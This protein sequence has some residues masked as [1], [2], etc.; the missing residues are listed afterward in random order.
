MWVRACA[1]ECASVRASVR[2]CVRVC[3]R[4]CVRECACVCAC[5][6]VPEMGRFHT[7]PS[8][9]SVGKNC[10]YNYRHPIAINESLLTTNL[11]RESY[12]HRHRFTQSDSSHSFL[13]R[14]IRAWNNLPQEIILAP[15]PESFRAQLANKL[16]SN[17]ITLATSSMTI[18]PRPGI[19]I[20]TS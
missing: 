14:T 11:S 10:H 8:M 7:R 3:V 12:S 5:M 15:S 4:A 20:H 18:G 13:P 16:K 2:V 1:C 6:H 9:I 17:Q 19:P